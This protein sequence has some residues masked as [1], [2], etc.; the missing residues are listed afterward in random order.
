MT[1]SEL[2][3]Q[4]I[5]ALEV[6]RFARWLQL[7]PLVMAVIGLAM[8]YDLT[9]YRC[10]N[11]P[12]AMDAAQVARHLATGKGYTTDYIRPFSVYLLQKH[13]RETQS[14]NAVNLVA[15]TG[16]Q[17][18]LANAPVYPTV[19]AG[20]I[21]VVRPDWKVQTRKLFWS[22]GGRFMRYQMEFIIALMNQLLLVVV[23]A[24]TFLITRKLF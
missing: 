5:R 24:L 17:P 23:V 21:K 9:S 22:E 10:F 19:L 20:L 4:M 1:L 3:Q 7:F 6:G 12:E 11:S 8:L 18:D 13:N 16:T 14:T 15:M 2:V